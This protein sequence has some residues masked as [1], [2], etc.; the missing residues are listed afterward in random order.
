MFMALGL[1]VFKATKFNALCRV[2]SND[3]FVNVKKRNYLL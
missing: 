3:R 1:T 2:I